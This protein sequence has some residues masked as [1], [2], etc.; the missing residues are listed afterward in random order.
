MYCCAVFLYIQGFVT[1]TSHG[2]GPRRRRLC[3]S[4]L[5]WPLRG[6]KPSITRA[7]GACAH[8]LKSMWES[9][10][11]I[12]PQQLRCNCAVISSHVHLCAHTETHMYRQT[13]ARDAHRD[14]HMKRHAEK[15]ADAHRRTETCRPVQ[16]GTHSTYSVHLV[17]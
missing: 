4:C 13:Q 7:P 6:S 11:G 2:T 10:S 16:A 5:W 14:I 17:V 15:R 9:C 8:S 12:I 3:L 1:Q